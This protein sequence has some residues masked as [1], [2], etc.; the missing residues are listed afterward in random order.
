[1]LQLP[2]EDA[3]GDIVEV[4]GGADVGVS[5][6]KGADV[7]ASVGT[8]VGVAVGHCGGV[9]VGSGVAATEPGSGVHPFPRVSMCVS[10]SSRCTTPQT[11]KPNAPSRPINA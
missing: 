1:M 11:D 9:G 10:N 4:G 8:G 2:A 6:G 5:V 7:G 3:G